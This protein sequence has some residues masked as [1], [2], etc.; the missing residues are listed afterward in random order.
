M[1]GLS[2]LPI[3]TGLANEPGYNTG[4][5][6][7]H[8]C[9]K[10]HSRI[11]RRTN[12]ESSRRSSLLGRIEFLEARM[13]LSGNPI[14]NGTYN[15]TNGA[16]GL[17]LDDTKLSTTAASTATAPNSAAIIDQNTYDIVNPVFGR[18]EMWQ[19]TY[20]GAGYYTIVNINSGLYLE[21]YQG[22]TTIGVPL[23]QD[24]SDGG[25]D[26]LWSLTASGSSY[27]I[28]NKAS[29][30]VI[31]DPGSSTT[32]GT[33]QDLYTA[34]GGANQNW[35]FTSAAVVADGVYTLKNGK[36]SKYLDDPGSSTTV[37][38]QMVQNSSNGGY[39]Q[40]WF[41]VFNGAGFYTI[42]NVASSLYL[43]DPGGSSTPGVALEQGTADGGADQLWSLTPNGSSFIITNK[44]T[45][46]VFDDFGNSTSSVRQLICGRPITARTRIG[47]SLPR[48]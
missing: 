25:A 47:R 37:G 31:D 4:R 41:F 11:P 7:R 43:E 44:Q 40:A 35:N 9:A 30:L 28:A 38:K 32:A 29:G 17:Y 5:R 48:P 14:A 10:Y 1:R 46:L 8:V 12:Q 22:S 19:F 16:S 13:L 42:Q 3:G 34:N 2:R 20:N 36:S 18:D 33:N 24:N 26:Q 15:L 23:Y 27:I 21:D 39:D 45:G 6:G